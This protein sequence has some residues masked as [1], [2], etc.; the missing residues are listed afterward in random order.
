ME[1][2]VFGDI[3]VH[4][5]TED[6]LKNN[7]I[8]CLTFPSGK[9]YIGLTT[10]PLKERLREH[11][12]E[13]FRKGSK[14]LDTVKARAIRKYL[15]FSV[16]ILEE[17]NNIN[18]LNESEIKFIAKYDTVK[19]GYNIST[20]GGGSFGIKMTNETKLK[21]SKANKGHPAH[22]RKIVQKYSLTGDLLEE[23]KSSIEAALSMDLKTSARLTGAIKNQTSY[24]NYIWKYKE[25]I[26]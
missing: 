25:N 26:K 23:F 6:I 10:Q 21:I 13:S 17:C 12:K 1:I 22:N 3:K 2:R 15:E 24:H 9:K 7:V 8:Y 11:I 4:I 19:N 14:E 5:R 18:D 16:E 20:G